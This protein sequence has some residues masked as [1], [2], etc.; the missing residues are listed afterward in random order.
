[1]PIF[2]ATMRHLF[3]IM[4][5]CLGAMACFAQKS[6]KTKHPQQQRKLLYCSCAYTNYGLPVG[7]ISHSFYELIADKG[8][9]PCVVYCEERGEGPEKKQYPVTEKD[10]TALYNILQELNVQD[11]DGYNVDEQMTGGTSYRIHIEFADGK[12][13]TAFWF[14]H[15]PKGE[16]VNAY[17]TI[18]RFLSSKAPNKH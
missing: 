14:T 1:M 6:T 18:L 11:L 15:A 8:K 5:L 16:A 12:E 17:H 9:K 13:V 2:A 4:A 10:V 3:L 7:E